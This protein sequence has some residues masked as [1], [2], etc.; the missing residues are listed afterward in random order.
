MAD[1]I[2][3]MEE[4]SILVTEER[5]RELR[6]KNQTGNLTM[7]ECREALAYIKQ[8]RDKASAATAAKKA[9]AAAKKA[10]VDGDALLKGLLS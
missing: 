1:E 5:I 8:T 2:K 4:T 10:P 9:K 7:E 3:E 6:L